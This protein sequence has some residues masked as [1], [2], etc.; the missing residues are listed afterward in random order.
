MTPATAKGLKI[1]GIILL[2]LIVVYI[3]YKYTRPS[4]TWKV[5][6]GGDIINPGADIE[7]DHSSMSL[8]AAKK[9]A[10]EIGAKS[11]LQNDIHTYFK[12]VNSPVVTD[13][14]GNYYL[15]VKS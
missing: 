14:N 10:I 3:I 4:V 15:Y 9:H 6:K 2:V 11:F 8:E 12:N 13:P 7:V 1:G 5:I